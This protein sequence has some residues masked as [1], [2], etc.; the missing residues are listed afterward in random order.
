[1]SPAYVIGIDEVGRGPIAGPLCVGACLMSR[2]EAHRFGKT[3][4]GIKE[5]KQLAPDKREEWSRM[6]HLA[7]KEGECKLSTVFVSERVID[8]QGLAFALRRAIGKVLRKLDVK[9]EECEV[10]LDGGIKAPESFIFQQTI[11]KG[12]EKEPLIASASIVAKVR[13]DRYMTR[14]S[15]RYPDYGFE[16]HK[17][18]GTKRHY[19]ALKE[20]GISKV[21]RRS[22]LKKLIT[23]NV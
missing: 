7:A 8:T 6:L 10:L 13:R 17:G 11:I 2:T 14:L 21:H 9:P 20:H 4:F 18:Y 5:S 1:M 15:K 22:F 16:S 12:D 3:I 23:H 19:E